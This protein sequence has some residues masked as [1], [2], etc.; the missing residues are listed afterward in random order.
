[1]Q[2]TL[3]AGLY[4]A[5]LLT[6]ACPATAQVLPGADTL[7]PAAVADSQAVLRELQARIREQRSDAAAWH[8]LGMV[9][10]ALSDRGRAPNPPRGIDPTTLGALADSA[11][12]IA[13]RLAPSNATYRMAI[14]RILLS[15][16]AA[17]TRYAANSHF[18]AAISIAR[19]D[20]NRAV[21]AEA[22]IEYGRIH[23]RRYDA[24]ANRRMLTSPID[25]GRSLNMVMQPARATEGLQDEDAPAGS[26]DGTR[27]LGRFQE[28]EAL[29]RNSTRPLPSDV[30]GASSFDQAEQLFREAYEAS[31]ANARTFRSVAMVLVEHRRWAEMRAFARAHLTKTPWDGI[32]WMALG[33]AQ[34]RLE[35]SDAA[36]AAFDSAMS[37]LPSRE[38]ARLDQIERVLRPNADASAR[39]SD[40]ERA[41]R[42]RLYWTF[43]D[44]LWSRGGNESRVEFFARITYAELRWTVEELGVRGADSDRGDVYVRYGPPDVIAALGPNIQE[45][46]NDVVTFWIYKSGLLF[47]FSGMPTY[48]TARTPVDDRA[49]VAGLKNAIPVR[50]DNLTGGVPDSIPVQVARFRGGQDSVDVL[51]AAAPNVDS[52]FAAA[53]TTG[54]VRA[55]FWLLTATAA[56]AHFDT[57][58]VTTNGVRSWTRSVRAGAYVYRIEAASPSSARAGR[59]T[60]TVL[61][62]SDVQPG[63]SREGFGLSD[64]LLA[65]SVAQ[66]PAPGARWRTAGAAPLAGPARRGSELT[67]V[68][69]N[70]D[71]AQDS[72]VARYTVTLTVARNRSS[73]GR[74]AAQ[75]LGALASVAR[76]DRQED[77]YV[78]SYDRRVA[79]RAAFV[80]QIS[81]GLGE[82][83]A[84]SY[85][86]TI[87]VTDLVSGKKTSRTTSVRI[88]N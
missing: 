12:R 36:A 8:R 37:Y 15:S 78:V 64:L 35:D 72:G 23:W 46:A 66:Q 33:L 17:V 19:K 59:A 53:I 74:I 34:H 49:M 31:P 54:A 3:W 52:I 24:L 10:W 68:W 9:A 73:G 2:R 87:E 84:G 18:E 83:P 21:R 76:I 58:R 6:L 62:D 65:T 44:P 79:H 4:S 20:T 55:S 28:A 5:A 50:W 51:V 60:G 71:F 77:R 63:F 27:P 69:E 42:T 1:M 41:A 16:N 75:V 38:R 45:D 47:A 40:A 61:A 82:T 14:G 11:L 25:I 29:I 48:G 85:T 86:L 70:Y 88:G 43:A 56:V 80:D 39:G 81:I 13:S 26:G 32:A 22:A 30:T 57:A 7:S 67:V